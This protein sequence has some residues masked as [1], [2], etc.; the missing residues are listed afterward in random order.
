MVKYDRRNKDFKDF[1]AL[2][3][4]IMQC[5]HENESDEISEDGIEVEISD[6]S[7][8]QLD[9]SIS[10][11]S[12]SVEF[13][14]NAVYNFGNGELSVVEQSEDFPIDNDDTELQHTVEQLAKLSIVDR[15]EYKDD[16]HIMKIK[17]TGKKNT[18]RCPNADN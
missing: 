14:S 12:E 7:N 13:T 8:E 10:S 4:E 3:E 1:D 9:D 11:D 18:R 2:L 16:K 5:E 6:A 17:K 15:P